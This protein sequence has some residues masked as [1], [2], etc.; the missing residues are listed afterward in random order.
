MLYLILVSKINDYFS[1]MALW[2]S[3]NVQNGIIN[4][5]YYSN[6]KKNSNFAFYIIKIMNFQRLAND[7]IVQSSGEFN[8][9]NKQQLI[10]KPRQ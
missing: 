7:H 4:A 2:D 10:I 5:I 9:V 6:E 3:K 8:H 1:K